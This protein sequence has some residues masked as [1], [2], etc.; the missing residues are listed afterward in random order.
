MPAELDGVLLDFR[1]DIG[2]LRRLDLSETKLQVSDLEWH[3]RLPFWSDGGRPF[4]VTPM[5]VA[6]APHRYP[7]QYARTKAADLTYPLDLVERPNGPPTI[8]DGVHRLLK[9]HLCGHQAVRVRILPWARLDA[10][11]STSR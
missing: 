8:L 2:K 4:R 3:L 5:Q 11:V 7:E 9:S 6:V 10:I 1:W